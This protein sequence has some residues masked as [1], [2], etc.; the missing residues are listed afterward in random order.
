MFPFSS[1][2][3]RKQLGE[4]IKTL[5]LG[6]SVVTSELLNDAASPTSEDSTPSNSPAS[7]HCPELRACSACTD[8]E[9]E[10]GDELG[11]EKCK[12]CKQ[13]C[14]LKSC[15]RNIEDVEMPATK[16]LATKKTASKAEEELQPNK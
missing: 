4:Q 9:A 7:K 1:P 2:V 5:N 8:D 15:K 6:T 3:G 10:L 14:C 11:E 16:K 12:S 13:T